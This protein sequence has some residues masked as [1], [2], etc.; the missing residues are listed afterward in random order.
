MQICKWVA[1]GNENPTLVMKW[2][3]I[4]Q[5]EKW[6]EINK[7]KHQLHY[8]PSKNNLNLARLILNKLRESKAYQISTQN[9]AAVHRFC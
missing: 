1:T 8:A 3:D 9:V 7:P 4:D 6:E 2:I 5:V